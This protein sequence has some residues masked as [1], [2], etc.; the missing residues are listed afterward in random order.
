MTRYGPQNPHPLSL[1]KTELVWEGKYD[2]HGRKVQVA[3]PPPPKYDGP[4]EVYAASSPAKASN[5]DSGEPLADAS[6]AEEPCLLYQGDNLSVMGD[7]L[8]RLEGAIQLIYIDPPFDVGAD[9]HMRVPLGDTRLDQG[10]ASPDESAKAGKG[11]RLGKTAAGESSAGS[12]SLEVFNYR[13]RW[14]GD[15]EGYLAMM[16]QRLMLMRQLLKDSGLLFVHCD[17]RSNSAL[18]LLLDEVFGPERFLNEIVWHYYNKYSAGKHRLP[19]AHDSI[20]LYAKGP[21]PAL[22]PLST[23]RESPQKQLVRQN[24]NGVLKNARDENGKL[25]Y[26]LST[27]RKGDDVWRIPQMQPASRQWTGYRTQ[28]HHDLLRQV[29]ELASN[30][31]DIV[32]D[33]FCGSGT[34]LAQAEVMGRRWIGCDLGEQA[35][36]TTRKR[37]LM[38][39]KPFANTPGSEQSPDSPPYAL[40]PFHLIR[41]AENTLSEP[42]DLPRHN[43]SAQYQAAVLRCFGVKPIS[44]RGVIHGEVIH[45][46]PGKNQAT[47]VLVHVANPNAALDDHTLTRLAGEAAGETIICL[48]R[49]YSPQIWTTHARLKAESGTTLLP[50]LIGTTMLPSG[51]P[52]RIGLT[53]RITIKRHDHPPDEPE[54]VSL[55]QLELTG[56]APGLPNNAN[57]D[58]DRSKE[59][60]ALLALLDDAPPS[61]QGLDYLEGWSVDPGWRKGNP[62]RHHWW[63]FRTPRSRQLQRETPPLALENHGRKGAVLVTTFDVYGQATRILVRTTEE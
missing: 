5:G 23:L 22:N 51:S 4:S 45:A 38:A 41:L 14:G 34:S 59:L 50:V 35:I 57:G 7:L 52:S 39:R 30:P 3:P 49:G 42:P 27:H 25:R 21:R 43:D 33:F 55:C 12:T 11:Q 8:P 60:P 10:G 31:G 29:I 15:E 56:Y 36:H 9:F 63:G 32:A 19:R 24:V 53:P 46:L 1:L 62:H 61:V 47:R 44:S 2:A 6:L 48:A 58:E 16:Y 28:K 18:R 54:G 40:P 20:L 17:W 13:D 37:L 26:R